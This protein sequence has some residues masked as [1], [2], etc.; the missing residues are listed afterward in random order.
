MTKSELLELIANGENSGVEFKRDDLRPEQLAKEVVALANFR[1]GRIL[2]G[3]ED[4]GTITGIQRTNPPTERWVMDTVFGRYIHPM[5]IPFYEEVQIDE[6]HRVSVVTVSQGVS[7]PYVVRNQ[8]R[9]DIY[10]RVGSISR[11]ATREQQARL[12]ALGGMLHAELLPVSGSGLADLSLDRLKDYLST[13]VGDKT[14]PA[15]DEEWRTRLCGL[16]FM[17]ER[18]DGPAV[19]TIAGLVL[20]GHSPRRLLHQAGIRWMA[21]EGEDK[22]YRALDDRVVDGALLALWKED[23]R[24]NRELTEGGLIEKLVDAM[25]P[26]VSEEASEVDESMR[27]ERRWLYPVEALREAIVNALAHRDWTRYEEVEV[28]RFGDRLEVLSPGALQ[29]SMTV[30]KMIAGQRSP[31]NSLIVEVLRD[32][33]YVDARGMGVR[34][35]IIPLLREQNGTEPEFIATEDHLRLV[36]Y[37]A[38]QDTEA[39]D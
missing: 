19:C 17:V 15:S 25:Q 5:I 9:E 12:Y 21:F 34:N 18:E 39:Q 20:F 10:I 23:E 16:G 14:L 29:N 26:F 2:L 8:D 38:Q 33:G 22:S 27:R 30:E 4:D 28:S 6:Q 35:K 36:M 32:Y 1:G 24:G 37:I 11:L 31:R 7:K 13:I 3:V